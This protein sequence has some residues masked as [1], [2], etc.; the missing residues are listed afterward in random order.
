LIPHT[1]QR[2]H[3]THPNKRREDEKY[4]DYKARMKKQKR[5]LKAFRRGRI[6]YLSVTKALAREKILPGTKDQPNPFFG[7][8]QAGRPYVRPV[9]K[10]DER[11]A[12]AAQRAEK[13][14][15][16]SNQFIDAY[17]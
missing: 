8:P 6:A 9:S 14:L 13:A 16:E 1:T 17:T 11:A 4:E 2:P 7:Y 10:A 5:E 3:M 15:S 12:V